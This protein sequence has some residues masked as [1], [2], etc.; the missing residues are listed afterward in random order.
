MPVWI[1]PGHPDTAVTLTL[2]YG[3]TQAGKV[4]IVGYCWGGLLTWRA[5]TKA[6]RGEDFLVDS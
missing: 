4:G 3:R 5:A 1:T 6:E 2:G